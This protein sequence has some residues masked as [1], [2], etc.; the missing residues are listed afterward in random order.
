[1]YFNFY[2][3][4]GTHLSQPVQPNKVTGT[5]DWQRISFSTTAPAGTYEVRVYFGLRM[6][7]EPPGLIVMAET[8]ESM[9]DSQPAG[10]Q[11]L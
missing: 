2:K 7:P 10:G 5:N 11:L 9:S 6:P 8:G 4:D 3:K 1:M